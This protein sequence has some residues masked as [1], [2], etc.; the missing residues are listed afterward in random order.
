VTQHQSLTSLRTSLAGPMRTGE[1]VWLRLGGLGLD[2]AR[3]HGALCNCLER[4]GIGG[5]EI[6][7]GIVVLDWSVASDCSAEGLV[8]FAVLAKHLV[9]TGVQVFAAEP[10]V[11]GIAE[12]LAQ[13]GF[14]SGCAGVEWVP[15]D[16]CGGG[17]AHCGARGALF[18]TSPNESVDDFCDD[19]SATLKRLAVPRSVRC[20]IMGTAQEVLHNVLSHA[21]ASHGAAAAL[22]FPRRRPK[23]LQ[24]GI[25]D[26]GVG[27]AGT[28]LRHPRHAWLGWFSDAQV[29]E[30]VLRDHRSVRGADTGEEQGGGGLAR[31]VKRLLAE[32]PS[33]VILR[34]GSAF[35]TLRSQDPDHFHLRRLTYGTGTQFRLEL[36]LS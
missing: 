12:V 35:V 9:D 32:T 10:A 26:D 15:C 23:V 36:P 14:R 5:A 27:I 34:S 17:A 33:S 21:E 3:S 20:A 19:L 30:A 24:I 2:D 18:S 13:S 7:P 11:S 16:A 1:A 29:T 8:F 6:P 22:I 31:L 28:I 25:A 4:L